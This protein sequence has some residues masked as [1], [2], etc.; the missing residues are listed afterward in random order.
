MS[1]ASPSDTCF[2]FQQF[3]SCPWSEVCGSIDNTTEAL[4][5]RWAILGAHYSFFRSHNGLLPNIPQNVYRWPLVA[6]SAR[7]G[8]EMKYRLLDYIY[9][10]FHRQ[11]VDGTLLLG[12]DVVSTLHL[13][14]EMLLTIEGS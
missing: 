3:S 6:D 11:T 13:L 7:K 4:C 8:I 1:T 2:S 5:V 12:T 14:R 10:A 9:T